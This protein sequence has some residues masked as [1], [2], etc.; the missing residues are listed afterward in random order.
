[1]L[2]PLFQKER[3]IVLIIIYFLKIMH[4]T[5]IVFVRGAFILSLP[6]IIMISLIVMNI[7]VKAQNCIL[8][9]ACVESGVL[10]II[11]STMFTIGP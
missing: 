10:K 2:L 4:V 3:T 7:M 1:M 9:I 5:H 11:P 8:P 6:H